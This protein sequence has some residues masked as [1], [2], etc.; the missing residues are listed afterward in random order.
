MRKYFLL[1][2]RKEGRGWRID[3]YDGRG[4]WVG[5]SGCMYNDAWARREIHNIRRRLMRQGLKPL[6]RRG[7]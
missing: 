3:E 2:L 4:A 5:T 6:R 1:T 7:R